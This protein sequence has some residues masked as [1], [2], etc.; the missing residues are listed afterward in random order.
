VEGDKLVNDPFSEVHKAERFLG[1]SHRISRKNFSYNST[2][3]FFCIKVNETLERCLNESKGRP[4]PNIKPEVI[5]ALR[6]FYKPY[7]RQ[8]YKLTGKNFGWSEY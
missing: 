8:F 6:R 5:Q 2:K 3:G 4:H 1:L 7:N